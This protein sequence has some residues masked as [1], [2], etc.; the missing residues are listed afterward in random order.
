MAAKEFVTCFAAISYGLLKTRVAFDTSFSNRPVEAP[1]AHAARAAS[2][3]RAVVPGS[4]MRPGDRAK[5][6]PAA[7]EEA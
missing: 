3:M 6:L 4:R 7:K 2:G 1:P 5:F